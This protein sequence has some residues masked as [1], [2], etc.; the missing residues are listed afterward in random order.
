ME[1]VVGAVILWIIPIFVAHA[2]GKP[3]HR[4]GVLYGAFLG[5]LGVI[6]VAVLPAR[7]AM[8]LEELERRRRN[9]TPYQ[10]EKIKAEIVSERVTRECPHCKEQMRRDASV[11]PRCQRESPAWTFHE[12]RWWAQTEGQWYMLDEMANEWRIH[13][14]TVTTAS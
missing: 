12:G 7:E 9:F 10:Y 5:W 1:L 13:E 14:D 6:V 3:K 8:T 4:A 11:C 2:I